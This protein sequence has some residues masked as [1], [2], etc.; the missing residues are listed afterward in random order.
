[1]RIQLG[2]EEAYVLCRRRTIWHGR[3]SPQMKLSECIGNG[4]ILEAY[5]VEM[6]MILMVERAR[7][8]KEAI[9]FFLTTRPSRTPLMK[10]FCQQP[11]IKLIGVTGMAYISSEF[12][13]L[14]GEIELSF[15][16]LT[17]SNE[18]N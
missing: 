16:V 8:R 18:G 9:H 15:P 17:K 7:G 2:H 14:R 1:M 13:R 11:Q 6:T 5:R 4:E 10:G 3:R 12:E